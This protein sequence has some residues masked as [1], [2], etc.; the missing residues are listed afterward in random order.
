MA[1]ATPCNG[2]TECADG[3][4]EE[5]CG[6]PLLITIIIVISA[7][8][9]LLCTMFLYLAR[10]ANKTILT[11]SKDEYIANSDSVEKAEKNFTIAI[12]IS[13]MEV[14]EIKNVLRREKTVHGN[15]GKAICYLKVILS[16]T[17]VHICT[18]T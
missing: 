11:I 2:N 4:D 5:G 12:L 18:L 13:K 17:D 14:H 3:S 1:W 10:E 15:E 16:N 8:V 9:V 6:S 7:G